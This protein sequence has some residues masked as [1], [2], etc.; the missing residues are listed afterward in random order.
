[1]LLSCRKVLTSSPSVSTLQSRWCLWFLGL[2]HSWLIQGNTEQE[3]CKAPVT[4]EFH[5]Q[6][7]QFLQQESYPN[8]T[9]QANP[10]NLH[11]LLKA[12]PQNV[13][14]FLPLFFLAA[15]NW[16]FGNMPW[17]YPCVHAR[18]LWRVHCGRLR[19][20][21]L[22]HGF[23]SL[24]PILSLPESLSLALISLICPSESFHQV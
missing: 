3:T 22:Y 19:C 5:H 18:C 4:T 21:L 20:H 1:M 6:T 8:Q 13:P 9:C 14:E 12:K 16:W 10:E 11:E 2:S 17:V 7:I 24:K 23:L 15:I